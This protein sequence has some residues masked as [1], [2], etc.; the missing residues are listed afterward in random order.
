M[1][2]VMPA[3]LFSAILLGRSISEL[4]AAI[5]SPRLRALANGVL[6]ALAVT[7]ISASTLGSTEWPRWFADNPPAIAARW[8]QS[9]GLSQGV[10]E[11][12]SSNL[13]TAMSSNVLSVRS[14]APEDGRLV[15]YVW[16]SDAS[17]YAQ[18]PQFAIWQDRNQT[19][20]TAAAVQ[21]TYAICRMD[22]VAGYRIAVLAT[23]SCQRGTH[24]L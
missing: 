4:L 8:L 19:G 14:V 21:A 7:T 11:Y 24:T 22:L 17:L 18:P 3:F 10:G 9:H 1:R 15:P 6:T 13:V 20:V 5:R 12:W 2:Y 16:S 23:A